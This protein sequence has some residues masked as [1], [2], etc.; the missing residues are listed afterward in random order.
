MAPSLNMREE[1]AELR[2]IIPMRNDVPK[3]HLSSRAERRRAKRD[4]VQSRDLVFTKLRDFE[5]EKRKVPPLGLKPSVG[6]TR[7]RGAARA[8]RVIRRRP[9]AHR[10]V[11]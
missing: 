1:I 9:S 6:M 7:L 2:R 11:P 5:H 10:S 4:G 3:R 8:L